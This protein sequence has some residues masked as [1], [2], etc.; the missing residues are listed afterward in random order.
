MHTFFVARYADPELVLT[1]FYWL[2]IFYT[3]A[4]GMRT[5]RNALS[6]VL[7]YI[8]FWSILQCISKLPDI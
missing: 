5:C 8:I 4:G 7:K 2:E 3:P 1:R 6:V